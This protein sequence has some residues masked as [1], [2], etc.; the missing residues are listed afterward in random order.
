MRRTIVVVL[1]VV[2]AIFLA[3]GGTLAATYNRLVNVSEQVN[4]QW[5]QIESQLQRRYDLIPNLVETVKGY[6]AHEQEV[7]TAVAEARARLAGA[8]STSEQVQAANQMESALA[9]L[10]VIV[11][12]YPDLKANEQFNR[13]MDELAGTENR[14]NVARM[15]YNE[16]VKQYNRIIRTFPTVLLAGALG[17]DQRPYFQAQEG[18]ETAPRVNFGK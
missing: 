8:A 5:A 13:M 11:E 3:A 6:A 1:A 7:F 18:A 14:I 15:R 12:R 4:E 2:L 10:L 17:F 9:R 16:A